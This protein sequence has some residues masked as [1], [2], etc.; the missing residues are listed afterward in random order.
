MKL[1]LKLISNLVEEA[2]NTSTQNSTSTSGTGEVSAEPNYSYKYVIV[3]VGDFN[4]V[5]ISESTLIDPGALLKAVLKYEF[6]DDDFDFKHLSQDIPDPSEGN[7]SLA[8]DTWYAE[9]VERLHDTFEFLRDVRPAIVSDC[10]IVH[11]Q[12][13]I[14]ICKALSPEAQL[15]LDDPDLHLEPATDLDEDDLDVPEDGDE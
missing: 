1:D 13:L 4:M 12:C 15:E 5:D 9:N 2:V 8:L 11:G 7:V 10:L 14:E 6:W 3:D